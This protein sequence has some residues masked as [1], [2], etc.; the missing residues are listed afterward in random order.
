MTDCEFL[1]HVVKKTCA[2][3]RG[4]FCT[5]KGSKKRLLDTAIC[6]DEEEWL[7]CPRYLEAHPELVEEVIELP[8]TEPVTTISGEDVEMIE[9]TV[10][11]E[12][13]L[14]RV[15]EKIIGPIELTLP[16]VPQPPP[17]DCPYLGPVPDGKYGC[18]G[19][20]CNAKDEPLRVVKICKSRP[21]WRECMRRYKAEKRGVKH[22]MGRD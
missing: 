8:P 14:P 19:Y 13:I 6:T 7:E 12:P 1:L 18:C 16:I 22:A 3:C 10:E 15:G 11:P 9:V 20:W 17:T 21:S 4:W 2:G 5:S